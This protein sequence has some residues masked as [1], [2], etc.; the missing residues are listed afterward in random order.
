MRQNNF[1]V[2]SGNVAILVEIVDVKCKLNFGL[3]IR[4]VNLEKSLY[5]LFDVNVPVPIQIDDLE[6]SLANNSRQ[7][8]VIVQ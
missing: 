5:E 3:E 6:E 8:A 1:Y 2:I 4:V 7:L